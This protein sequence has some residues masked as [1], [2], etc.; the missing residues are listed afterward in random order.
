MKEEIIIQR[1]ISQPFLVD[2]LKFDL[3]L[4]V[5]VTGIEDGDIH[6]FLADE[7]M[8]RFCTEPY[9]KPAKSNTS[10]KFMHITSPAINMSSPSYV[11]NIGI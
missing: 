4:F 2:Q 6:A 10:N 9:Q 1:Y 8:A 7:G 5:V 11:P 3:R